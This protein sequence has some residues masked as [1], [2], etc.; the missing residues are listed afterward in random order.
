MKKQQL[1]VYPQQFE[2][3]IKLR[4]GT[5]VLLR[6]IKPMDADNWVE[7]YNSLSSMSKYYRFFTSHREPTPKM[8]KQYT[9]IDYVNNFAIV[10]IIKEDGREMMVGVARYVLDPPPDSA[11][12]AIAIADAWQGKGLGT[13]MLLH[14]LNIMIRH[15]IKKIHGDVFLENRRMLQL[16][17]KGGFELKKEDSHGIRH[18]EF[19]L[20]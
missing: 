5:K 1:G 4:D 3:K 20:Q 19:S 9:E 10:A 13:K 8:I 15:K 18:F 14:I 17:Y 11:E 2:K 6:P 7:L 12:L 16:M